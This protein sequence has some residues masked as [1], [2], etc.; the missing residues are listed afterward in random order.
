MEHVRR[1]MF[2]MQ[3]DF[4]RIKPDVFYES[5]SKDELIKE[6]ERLDDDS[7]TNLPEKEG[8]TML[9]HFQRTRTLACWHDSS[10]IS[11]ASHFMVMFNTLY[12]PA[13]FYA[14]EEYFSITGWF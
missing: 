14:D 8:A 3:K 6:F 10:S 1:A 11:N 2:K 4:L 5:I 12:D 7:A 9:K 13:I